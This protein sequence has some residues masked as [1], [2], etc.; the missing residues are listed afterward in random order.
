MKI[1]QFQTKVLSLTRLSGFQNEKIKQVGKKV[2]ST[3]K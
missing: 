2:L 1:A 3:A